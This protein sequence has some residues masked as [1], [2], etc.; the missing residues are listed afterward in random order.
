MSKNS[1]VQKKSCQI[2]DLVTIPCPSL[3]CNMSSYHNVTF[4][5]YVYDF[6]HLN[7]QLFCDPLILIILVFIFL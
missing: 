3:E 1:E 7:K 6:L 5:T 4:F 2:I